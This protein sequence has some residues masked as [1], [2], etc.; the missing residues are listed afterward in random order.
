MCT[1]IYLRI[2]LSNFV[3]IAEFVINSLLVDYFI[4]EYK[5]IIE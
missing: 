2:K 4:L 5:N 1:Q 3:F